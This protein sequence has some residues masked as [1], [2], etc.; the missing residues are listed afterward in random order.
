MNYRSF[1]DL[2]GLGVAGLGLTIVVGAGIGLAA[3][4][5][6]RFWKAWQYYM[7]ADDDDQKQRGLRMIG[8]AAVLLAV[9]LTVVGYARYRTVAQKALEQMLLGLT[10]GNPVTATV[11]L[12]AGNLLVFFVGF[13]ITYA[14]HDENPEFADR[15][16]KLGEAQR[17]FDAIERRELTAKL[18]E[19]ARGYRQKVDRLHKRSQGMARQPG[20]AEVREQFGRL[21]AKDHEVVGLLQ[22]YR[23]YLVSHLEGRDPP[24]V[25]NASLA[26]RQSGHGESMVG[27]SDFNS[28]ELRLYRG[29]R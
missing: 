3:W 14:I 13:A 21:D 2:T 15:S 19:A 6:G 10:P 11:L 27:L 28:Q 26:E 12:L 8:L 29:G 4:L 23:G 24:F 18:E 25:F 17:R 20:Y 16:K 9:T 7:R 5:A 1:A 22:S